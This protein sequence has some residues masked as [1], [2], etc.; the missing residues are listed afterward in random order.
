MPKSTITTRSESVNAPF[1]EAQ[2]LEIVDANAQLPSQD[3]V[4][5]VANKLSSISSKHKFIIQYT[6]LK[7]RD[8]RSFDL[9]I[10]TDFVASWE[11][12]KDGCVVVKLDWEKE[13]AEVLK[14]RGNEVKEAPED[15]L[16]DDVET[17]KN[18]TSEDS[19]PG[20]KDTP[21]VTSGSEANQLNTLLITIYWISI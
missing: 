14:L 11:P 18:D 6:S 9:N 7:G 16:V 20:S 1:S 3:L 12:S 13:V 19:K 17:E 2:L 10:S 4:S 8:D 21:L 5:E 15:D